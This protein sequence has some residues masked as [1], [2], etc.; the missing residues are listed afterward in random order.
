M[1][2]DMVTDMARTINDSHRE[3]N[4]DLE[5]TP[6]R[7]L[8]SFDWKGLWRY[9]DLLVLFVRRDFVSQFKQT[10]L[11]PMWFFIQPIFTTII[12]TV[13]FGSLA[14]LGT[15]GIPQP[16]FYMSGII[17]WNYFQNV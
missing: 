13:V 10:I 11:G 15:D 14:K 9:R 12:F 17:I 7:S 6:S 5:I 2:M 3:R 1:V 8:L 4:W 16:L